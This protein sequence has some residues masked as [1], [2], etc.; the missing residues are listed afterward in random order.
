MCNVASSFFQRTHDRPG[1]RQAACFR[2]CGCR[3]IMER[4]PSE[5]A[6]LGMISRSSRCPFCVQLRQTKVAA[7]LQ[8]DCPPYDCAG[9]VRC[10]L[11]G[12]RS[13]GDELVEKFSRLVQA[14]VQ[15]GLGSEHRED[16]EDACQAVFLR[17]FSRLDRWDGRCPFCKWMAVVAAHRVIDL[18]RTNDRVEGLPADVPDPRSPPLSPSTIEC[19]ERILAQLP[20]ERRRAHDLATRKVPQR[21]IAQTLGVSLRTIQYWLDDV[22]ELLLTCLEA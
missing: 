21:E 6:P 3:T 20:S 11:A 22:R 9:R 17:V 4:S 16:W 1:R 19:F 8:C 13:A 18:V 14:I 10:Y 5:S 15:R 12:D 2:W 7:M